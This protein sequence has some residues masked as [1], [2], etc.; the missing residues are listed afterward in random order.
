MGAGPEAGRG[1]FFAFQVGQALSK[2]WC[3]PLVLHD[4]HAR[5]VWWQGKTSVQPGVEHLWSL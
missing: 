2:E 4:V 1:G 3:S 5:T